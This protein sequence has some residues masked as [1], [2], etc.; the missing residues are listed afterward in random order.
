M[1]PANRNRPMPAGRQGPKKG[2]LRIYTAARLMNY[3]MYLL[4]AVWLTA[5]KNGRKHTTII[6]FIYP[7]FIYTSSYKPLPARTST[8]RFIRFYILRPFGS[9]SFDPST[10]T[11]AKASVDDAAQDAQEASP[12]L[13]LRSGQEGS[14]L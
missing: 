4:P 12:P 1:M 6:H 8:A 3:F 11:F 9:A 5:Q 13:R 10:S 14:G 2:V 7:Y